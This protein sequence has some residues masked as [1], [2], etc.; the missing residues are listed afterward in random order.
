MAESKYAL[1]NPYDD[2]E[3]DSSIRICSGYRFRNRMG[4]EG[5]P[6]WGRGHREECQ[7]IQLQSTETA[8]EEE[9]NPLPAED[10]REGVRVCAVQWEPEARPHIREELWPV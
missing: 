8:P 9:G 1:H 3:H 5:W 10:P 7:D 2:L 4:I 6:W